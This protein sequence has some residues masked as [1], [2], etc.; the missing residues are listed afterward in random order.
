MG[1]IAS[2]AIAWA[3]GKNL[4]PTVILFLLTVW[5][6]ISWF[7]FRA[8]F[9]APDANI[10]TFGDALWWGVV[11]FLTVGYG[12]RVPV[13]TEGRV[14]AGILMTS[15]VVTVGILT[16]KISSYFMEKALREGRGIVDST[17]L[18]NHFVVC[19]W[20][21]EMHQLLVHILDFNPGLTQTQLVLVANLMQPAVDELRAHPR[22]KEMQIIVGDYFS[23]IN[24][25]RAA[26]ERARKVMILADR[27]PHA[28]GQVPSATEID[29]KT[30]M[31]SMTLSSIARGTLVAAEILDPKMD[32][33]LKLASVSEI[34]YSREYNRLLLVN[35]SGGTG[36]ANIIFDLLDPN[37]SA[38]LTTETI[39]EPLMNK[40]YGDLRKEFSAKNSERVLI[41]I[42]ENSGSRHNI[43]ELALRKAQRT[44]DVNQLLTNLRS[45]KELRCNQPVFHPDDDYVVS[46]GSMAI[47]ISHRRLGHVVSPS[48][49]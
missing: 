25:K 36:V 21:E 47:V 33:Y 48:A 30:I 45:V 41:G 43:K 32:Q 27:T 20:K 17:R 15:G 2:R 23:E 11:T 7:V 8:E 24:L 9:R 6:V 14:L 29:A 35:A 49:A 5:V 13:T 19:G 37:T 22:L 40:S 26:P 38:H 12:D 4:V 39:P 46:E 34:I 3:L 42:L 1:R 28:N 18:K 10:T 44:T 31:T 16:A